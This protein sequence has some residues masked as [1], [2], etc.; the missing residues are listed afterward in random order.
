MSSNFLPDKN[1]LSLTKDDLF[2]KIINLKLIV[3]RPVKGVSFGQEADAFI[4]RSDY[5]AV[6][7]KQE[8]TNVFRTG[9]FISN[10]YYIRKCAYKPS[11]KVQY[12]RLA[13]DT[14]VSLDIFVNNFIIF[15]SKGEAMATFNKTDYDLVG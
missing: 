7:P 6:F 10:Q 4:I 12:K 15:T 5:E 2:D 8:I 9:Q 14:L 13:K 3:K 1:K 11:I